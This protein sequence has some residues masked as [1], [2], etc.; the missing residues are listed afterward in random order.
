L[1]D[2]SDTPTLDGTSVDGN[3][4]GER[5]AMPGIVRRGD[6]PV[7]RGDRIGRYT[8]LRKLGS[9]GMGVVH[10]AFDPRLDRQVALK[11]LDHVPGGETEGGSEGRAQ[12]RLLREAQ[13]MARL[14]H[15]N[16]VTVHEVDTHDDQVFMAMEYVEGQTLREWM[17]DGARPW[18]EV[19]RV[20]V[21][22]GRGLAAA[23]AAGVVHRDFKPDNVMLG[24]DGRVRV[25]DFGLARTAGV[26]D[27]TALAAEPSLSDARPLSEKVTRTGAILGTP[28]YM[29]PEQHLGQPADAR[30]DQFSFAV[31]LYQ[32]LYGERP[33]AGKT[34]GQLAFSVTQGEVRDPPANADVPGWLHAAVLRA[35]A[36]EPEQ[37]WPC[38]EALLEALQRDASSS[39]RRMLLYGAV[40]LAAAGAGVAVGRSGNPMVTCDDA[41]QH[42]AGVWDAQR[43][44]TLRQ[45]FQ[46]SDSPVAP[47]SLESTVDLLDAYAEAWTRE[48]VAACEATH[49]Q[50]VQ[51]SALLDLRTACLERRRHELDAL[52][53]ALVEAETSTVERSVQAAAELSSVEAC[54]DL[55]GLLARMPLPDDEE[56]RTQ[57]EELRQQ[58]SRASAL[59]S[60]GQYEA[61]L[62]IA[63]PIVSR[64]RE[65]GHRPLEAAAGLRLGWALARAGKYPEA[66][67]VLVEAYRAARAGGDHHTAAEV[68][69]ML[70][71]LVGNAMDRHQDGL[72]WGL[73]AMADVEHLGRG[74]LVHAQLLTNL[75]GVY[76]KLARF[77]EAAQHH[78]EALAIYETS[79]EKDHPRTAAALN[80]LAIAQ[81][82]GGDPAAAVQTHRRAL[83]M[84]ERLAG[85]DHPDV[86][87][88][89]S[90]LGNALRG[91]GANDEAL[92]VH[93]RAL[94]IR[95]RTLGPDH[96]RVAH[97]I[98]SLAIGYANAGRLDEAL[99]KF[100]EATRR[101]EKAHGKDHIQVAAS[102]SNLAYALT[103][104]DQL[105]EA[106]AA[107]QRALQIRLKTVGPEHPETATSHASI[108]EILAAQG[109]PAEALEHYEKSLAIYEA[110]MPQGNPRIASA[111]IRVAA[112]KTE[113]G[114]AREAVRD[115][116]RA[117]EILQGK[118]GDPQ[119]VAEAKFY[120]ADAVWRA[121]LDRAR[122]RTLAAESEAIYAEQG[123]GSKRALE[124]V[125]AWRAERG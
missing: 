124:A 76:T 31:A 79:F 62:S 50:R 84:R 6:V 12:R 63:E 51:S 107:Q 100:R 47:A 36:V 75:G 109:K 95:E 116:E 92:R 70:A 110:S 29:S 85:E 46:A 121:G 57:V 2:P 71:W 53:G 34:A 28:A 35:L 102:L 48:R 74:T 3:A 1:S 120:L 21:E 16:V 15:P 27:E 97:S 119:Q 59:E 65:L 99:E 90:N 52:V 101:F 105:D 9:G 25:M 82:E 58:L 60:V 94:E 106:M 23:H 49:V 112:A 44:Q 111:L 22:A 113:L 13:A 38:M 37:R 14:A 19:R 40:A 91:V 42:L 103:L 7:S 10:A 83:E 8:I 81:L 86:A 122:A 123:P 72:R 125:Q 96:P 108:G 117:L 69:A 33:F 41:R 89:L 4:T 24:K 11:L 73:D 64:A 17:D 5:S 66:E 93:E 61:A 20:F 80:N 78:R 104:A 77:E 67:G 55:D 98:G 115:L 56:T 18:R 87:T 30:S 118:E 88:S 45:A 68:E 114:R 39:R 32:A 54:G 26:A 43:K